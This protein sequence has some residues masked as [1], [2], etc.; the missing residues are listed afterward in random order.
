MHRM[1]NTAGL[2]LLALLTVALATVTATA[3]AGDGKA[4]EYVVVY[5]RGVSAADGRAAR[6]PTARTRPSRARAPCGSA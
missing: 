6:P 1:R 4:R 2:G 3:G 5:E